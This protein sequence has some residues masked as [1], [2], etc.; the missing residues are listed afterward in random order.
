MC[1]K[2]SS[3]WPRGTKKLTNST[4]SCWT[5]GSGRRFC[6]SWGIR[7]SLGTQARLLK[8]P[9]SAGQMIIFFVPEFLADKR[10]VPLMSF[11]LVASL[12]LPTVGLKRAAHGVFI[13]NVI[14]QIIGKVSIVTLGGGGGSFF[15][16]ATW[17]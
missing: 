8:Q 4:W 15:S 13:E 7:G 3:C 9:A 6:A 12:M 5:R 2:N 16:F 1:W 10:P 11:I 17:R 14:W